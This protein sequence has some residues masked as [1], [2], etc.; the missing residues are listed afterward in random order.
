[1]C[2]G[3]TVAPVK[4]NLVVSP[5]RRFIPATDEDRDKARALPIGALLPVAIKIPRNYKH[6]C[7]FRLLVNFVADYHAKYR[8]PE[9]VM[10]E[11]KLRTGHYKEFIRRSTG[12]VVFIPLPTNFDEMDEGDFVNWSGK[13]KKVILE[14]LLPDFSE[15]QKKRL[16]R[17]IESWSEWCLQ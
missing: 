17:E 4:L 5:G 11:L 10:L 12:E 13:A 1:M 16:E 14:Q 15:Q 7:K 9:D 8:S 6:H 2:D 3:Y